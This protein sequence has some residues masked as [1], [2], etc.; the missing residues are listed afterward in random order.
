M[1]IYL[2]LIVAITFVACGADNNDSGTAVAEKIDLVCENQGEVNNIP[3]AAVYFLAGDSKV[4]IAAITVCETI[5]P[6]Q[7]ADYDIPAEALTAVG[8]WYAGAGDYLYAVREG[9]AVVVYR[10]MQDEMQEGSGFGYQP[11]ASYAK[12]EVELMLQ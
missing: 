2:L 6:E 9:E 7:Y 4:K 11:L 5:E 10:G 12:G 1:R 3:T 8:G